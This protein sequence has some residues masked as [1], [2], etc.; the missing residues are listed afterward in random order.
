MLKNEYKLQA[1]VL[2]SG[3]WVKSIVFTLLTFFYI[4]ISILLVDIIASIFYNNIITGLLLFLDVFIILPILYSSTVL[5]KNI[6][7]KKNTY[8]YSDLIKIAILNFKRI[9][10]I[11][12]VLF[13]ETLPYIILFIFFF[14]LFI[15]SILQNIYIYFVHQTFAINILLYL[16]IGFIFTVIFLH[17]LIKKWFLSLISSFVLDNNSTLNTLSVLKESKILLKNNKKK[18]FELFSSFSLLAMFS[19]FTLGIGFIVLLPYMKLSFYL[20][21][22]TIIL[23]K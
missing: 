2:L 10:K 8:N 19:I 4:I 9:L 23:K 1:K 20:L 17:I 18:F 3:K 11:H 6:N 7:T 15:W 14:I 12:G 16:I 22:E 5:I 21:Y 13:I